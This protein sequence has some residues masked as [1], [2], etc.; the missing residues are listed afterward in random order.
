MLSNQ[1][2]RLAYLELWLTNE[3]KLSPAEYARRFGISKHWAQKDFRAYENL[4]PHSKDL[5]YSPKVRAY[6]LTED[7]KPC[8]EFDED[9]KK[10]ALECGW[11]IIGLGKLAL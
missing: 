1:L 9:K 6:L 5:T 3:K 11:I 4:T 7:F 8:F 10:A 2:E